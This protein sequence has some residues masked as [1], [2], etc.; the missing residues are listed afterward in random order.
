[1][2]ITS[3]I[4]RMTILPGFS[5]AH[6]STTLCRFMIILSPMTALHHVN[7]LR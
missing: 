5:H 1:M 7:E 6:G 2:G 4:V 3:V